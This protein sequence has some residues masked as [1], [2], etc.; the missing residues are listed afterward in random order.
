M[1]GGPPRQRKEPPIIEGKR[2]PTLTAKKTTAAYGHPESRGRRF[3]KCRKTSPENIKQRASQDARHLPKTPKK[4][5]I[6]PAKKVKIATP[7]LLH[8]DVV[9]SLT[10]QGRPVPNPHHQDT[11]SYYN[12]PCLNMIDHHCDICQEQGS[13]LDPKLPRWCEHLETK[14]KEVQIM[15]NMETPTRTQTP[16]HLPNT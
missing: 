1:R 7:E 15:R 8:S 10:S 13:L 5:S 16:Q 11:Y 4:S 2:V 6:T 12:E 14:K 3:N 9:K